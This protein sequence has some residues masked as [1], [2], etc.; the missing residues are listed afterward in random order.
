MSEIKQIYRV[1]FMRDSFSYVG[2]LRNQK[3]FN[4]GDRVFFSI[5][6][7]D[8]S[9]GNIVGIELPPVQ[10]S[11]YEYKIQLPEEIIMQKMD[12][13]DFFAG[14]NFDKVVLTCERIFYTIEEAKE[15]ALKNLEIM[16]KLQKEEI[17]RYFGQFK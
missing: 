6:G 5:N 15:S 9:F 11:E 7:R 2:T 10:N 1:N 14:K 12:R 17:E 16:A 3:R 13:D 4:I 8:I